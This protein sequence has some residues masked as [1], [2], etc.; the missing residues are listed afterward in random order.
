MGNVLTAEGQLTSGC[1]LG[2]LAFCSEYMYQPKEGFIYYMY[3]S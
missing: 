3:V 2:Q 1:A